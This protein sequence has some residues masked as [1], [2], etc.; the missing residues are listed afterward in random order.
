MKYN[1]DVKKILKFSPAL[2]ILV[3]FVR[4][5]FNSLFIFEDGEIGLF[6][7][8]TVFYLLIFIIFYKFLKIIFKN[9]EFF[10]LMYISSWVGFVFFQYKSWTKYYYYTFRGF[11]SE[12]NNFAFLTWFFVLF[13]GIV[14]ISLLSKYKPVRMFFA[15]W[16]LL[17]LL[18]PV[19]N[20][21]FGF[22]ELDEN[23]NKAR[24]E[25]SFTN[26]VFNNKPDIYFILYDGLA[27][28]DTLDKYYDYKAEP[29]KN[30]LANNDFYIAEEA[31]SSYGTTNLSLATIF[32]AEYLLEDGDS[33]KVNNRH[34]LKDFD[35]FQ[36]EVF[37]TLLNNGYYIGSYSN[38]V[39]CDDNEIEEVNCLYRKTP[40]Q[41]IYQLL[42]QTPFQVIENNQ[43]DLPFYN[44]LLDIL[45]LQCAVTCGD[46][47]LI[48]LK[49]NFDKKLRI[50]NENSPKFYFFHMK[51]THGPFF[52]DENCQ[53][54][55]NTSSISDAI[56]KQD[57]Y[58][59][60]ILCLQKDLE[61]F[62]NVINDDSIVILQSDHG[63]HFS[64]SRTYSDL[65]DDEIQNRY[66]IFSSIRS[67]E[68]CKEFNEPNF[69]QINTFRLVFKCLSDEEIVLKNIKTFYVP[70]DPRYDNVV[71][72]TKRVR[73]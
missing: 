28:F 29:L 21:L 66:R 48:T 49:E 35:I 25:K 44:S 63:P 6:I 15:I 50:E 41:I 56:E 18:T 26:I 5:F 67:Q 24:Y 27:S 30:F 61:S 13:I 60:S 9:K 40:K 72:I 55:V 54:L 20:F 62:L 58:I 57:E 7:I 4:T 59:D 42:L 71:E 68:I 37:H 46:E 16:T 45:N 3:P 51:N 36:T 22:T 64:Y 14:V 73:Y 1:Y 69:G 12:I 32:E 38:Y 47:S 2:L 8:F 10:V 17:L 23:L 31:S 34:I 19:T 43:E 70:I 53:P 11:I 52:V 65:T 33:Y 39:T